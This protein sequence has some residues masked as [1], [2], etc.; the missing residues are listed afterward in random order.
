MGR[1]PNKTK[2]NRERAQKG[3]QVTQQK[4]TLRKKLPTEAQKLSEEEQ[5]ELLDAAYKWLVC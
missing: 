2:L 5:K 4:N 1:V 3:G